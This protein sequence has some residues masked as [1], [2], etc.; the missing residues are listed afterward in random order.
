MTV[1]PPLA[2]CSSSIPSTVPF[3]TWHYISGTYSPSISKATQKVFNGEEK[4]YTL[5]LRGVKLAKNKGYVTLAARV[6]DG[7]KRL[8]QYRFLKEV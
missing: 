6:V 2:P 5:F 4:R 7:D 1:C 8:T 3:M